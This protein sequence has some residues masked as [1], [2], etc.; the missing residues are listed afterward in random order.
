VEFK[1]LS[2]AYRIEVVNLLPQTE[3]YFVS[4]IRAFFTRRAQQ[5]VSK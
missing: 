1:I 4:T 2:T 5:A 3:E